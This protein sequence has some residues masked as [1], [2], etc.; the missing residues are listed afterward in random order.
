MFFSTY[1][2][3]QKVEN[4]RVRKIFEFIYDSIRESQFVLIPITVGGHLV[5]KTSTLTQIEFQAQFIDL[6]EKEEKRYLE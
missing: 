2:M 5:N 1:N 4:D 6:K 3:E